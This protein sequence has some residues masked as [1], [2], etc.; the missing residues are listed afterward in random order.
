[1]KSRNQEQSILPPEAKNIFVW[2]QGALGDVLLAGPALQAIAAHYP[3]ARLTLAGGTEQL[4]LLTATLPVAA[5]RSGHQGLWLELFQDNHCIGN[6]LK[7]L[8][9]QFDLALVLTPQQRPEFLDRLKLAGIPQV[10]WLPSFPVHDRVPIR[11]L[12][13]EKL[14]QAGLKKPLEPF[15]LKV[16]E[17]DSQKARARLQTQGHD[18]IF[19]VAL[20]PGSG[21]ARKN[22]PLEHYAGLARLLEEQYKAEIWWILGP[23]ETGWQTELQK[24]F[25]AQELRLLQDL[26]LGQLAAVLAEFQL[27]VGNDSGV[28]HLAAA[29]SRPAVVAIFGPSDPVIWAPPGERT[30]VIASE[31]PCAPCTPGRE[32]NCPEAVCLQA[33]TPAKVLAAIR[34]QRKSEIENSE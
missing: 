12:Q 24:E 20:A 11:E 5:V 30:I 19:R 9:S 32:I 29:L 16:P 23:A 31:Q 8:L 1:M 33:L 26:P 6:K 14:R 27:Y 21:H 7:N 3:G 10:L 18:Q 13:A 4:G 25:S 28:T 17:T 2:H 34:E 15:Q 22:W